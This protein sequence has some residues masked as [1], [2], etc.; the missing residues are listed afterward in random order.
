MVG[1]LDASTLSKIEIE[2]QWLKYGE[3]HKSSDKNV[4]MQCE[5]RK[6]IHTYIPSER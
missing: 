3:I 2:W 1:L 4:R 5:I 6:P